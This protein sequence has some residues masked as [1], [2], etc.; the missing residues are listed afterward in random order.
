MKNWWA[1]GLAGLLTLPT[2]GC[3]YVDG[4][5]I[6][7]A[8]WKQEQRTNRELIAGLELGSSRS[9]VIARLGTPAESEAF[10]LDGEEVRVLFYRT[11]WK[12]GDGATS[13]DE[14]TPLV[15]MNNRLVGWGSAVY[16]DL[17]I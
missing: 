17:R 6:S 5:H 12:E 1:L 15:F 16:D 9:D 14:T 7:N 2:S 3:V 4:E 11:H 13:R 10:E 8:D